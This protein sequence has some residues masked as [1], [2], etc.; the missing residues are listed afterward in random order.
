LSADLLTTIFLAGSALHDMGVIVQ[1]G[2]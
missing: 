1:Q 2:G